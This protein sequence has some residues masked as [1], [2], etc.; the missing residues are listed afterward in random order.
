MNNFL[1]NPQYTAELINKEIL[2]HNMFN[3]KNDKDYLHAMHTT[4]DKVKF[5]E[6]T[7]IY[8]RYRMEER[9]RLHDELVKLNYY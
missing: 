4:Q 3:E 6:I 9:I 8:N 5:D 2:Y 7:K 1:D